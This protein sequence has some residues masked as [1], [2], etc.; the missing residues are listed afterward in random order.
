MIKGISL[1]VLLLQIVLLLSACS[2]GAPEVK[3]RF[4]FPPPPGEARIEYLQGYFSDF[5]LKPEKTSFL[6][7]YVLGTD[8]PTAIFTTPVDV[9]SDGKGRVFVADSGARQVFVLDLK[10]HRSRVLSPPEMSG[11]LQRSFGVPF[12]VTVAADGR[13]YVSDVVAKQVD[14]FDEHERYLFSFGDPDLVRPTAVAV[15]MQ[16]E[17]VYVLDTVNHRLA[18]F[19]LQGRLIEYFG[20]RGKEP[21]QFNFPTDVDVDEQG[22]LY[23]LDSL[24]ARVQVFDETGAFLRMFGE[25]GTAEGSFEMAKNLAVSSSGQVYVTDALAH[26]LVI[27]S[28]EGDFLMR[29]G[30][31]SVVKNGISPGGFYLP[32]GVDADS[33]GSIWVVDSLNRMVHH[34]QLLTA[35]YKSEHPIS[36]GAVQT[37]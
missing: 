21:G 15:D 20:S 36:S 12:S 14:V 17:V 29:I 16:R 32:R 13:L 22:H 6:A 5:D 28:T 33:E 18:L 19:D 37:P 27:F 4:F 23:V 34:F 26:K 7:E 25:R 35:Q 1:H 2:T 31:K 10:K 9:A 11:G 8:R 30:G 3:K 24:N